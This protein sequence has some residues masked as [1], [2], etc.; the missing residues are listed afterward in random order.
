MNLL[1]TQSNVQLNIVIITYFHKISP[2][3]T[4]H[5]VTKKEGGRHSGLPGKGLGWKPARTSGSI[6]SPPS[7]CAPPTEAAHT[8]HSWGANQGQPELTQH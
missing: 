6:L 1:V 2:R 3:V 4:Q 8:V 5:T 7:L